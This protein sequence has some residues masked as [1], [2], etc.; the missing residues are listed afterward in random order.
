MSQSLS[1]AAQL[2]K[3][4]KEVLIHPHQDGSRTERCH[5]V[6]ASGCTVWDTNGNEILDVMGG[7]NWVAQV[8][9]G[10]PELAKAAADQI[11]TLDYFTSFDVYTS[12]RTVE[13][14][15]RIVGIAPP[16]VSKVFFTNGGSEGVETAMKAA[17]L[18][19]HYKGETDRVVFLSRHFA[20]HGCT[21]GSGAA[22][23]FPGI[24]VG[25]GPGLGNVERLTLPYE[26]R[27]SELYGDVDPTDFLINELE[28]TIAR[29]GASNIAAMIGEPVMGGGG[30]LAPPADYWPRV[31]EVLTR[32]GILLVADEV[33]TSYGRTGHWF[34]SAQRGMKAD[35]I[36]TA[37]G[38]TSGYSAFGAVLFSQEIAD[39]V[40]GDDVYFF[41]GHTF[42]GHP[43]ATAIALANLDVIEQD[44]L[45]DRVPEIAA[46]FTEALAPLAELPRV[47]DIRVVGATVGVELVA[48]QGTKVPVMAQ[49]VATEMRRRHRV[50]VRD[51]G[52]TLVFAP[53]LVV[54]SGHI[55]RAAEALH[56]TLTR[57]DADGQLA[58]PA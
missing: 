19:H 45:L 47:G 21:Y 14:A 32:N 57:L 12:D 8:G 16:E 44:R 24:H 54:E 56:E 34:D 49:G 41:H 40:A 6:R 2:A 17:R 13:L 18:Y 58:N 39:Q 7:G 22:T 26:Y 43:V 11:A 37:K 31:R 28:E 3:L 9:H 53:P 42:S 30:V 36:V 29:V 46:Q 15:A 10:R 5:I 38:L 33:V 4:D 23:G 35:I 50:I 52:P 27:A 25:I 55:E 48:D 51:Y 1:T 20:Y